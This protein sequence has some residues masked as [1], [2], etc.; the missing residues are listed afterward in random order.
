MCLHV[1]CVC[2]CVCLCVREGEVQSRVCAEDVRCFEAA[3][4]KRTF[5]DLD[6]PIRQ[7]ESCKARVNKSVLRA[8]GYVRVLAFSRTRACMWAVL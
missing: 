2:V 7:T 5:V 8:N 6:A 1:Y 4:R 3:L